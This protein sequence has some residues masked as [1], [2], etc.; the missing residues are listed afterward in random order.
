MDVFRGNDDH[1][2][3]LR[4]LVAAPRCPPGSRSIRVYV[5]LR[6]FDMSAIWA[7]KSEASNAYAR[8]TERENQAD[9]KLKGALLHPTPMLT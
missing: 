5:G 3:L 9:S 6:R 8:L 2:F 4:S 7:D 1:G